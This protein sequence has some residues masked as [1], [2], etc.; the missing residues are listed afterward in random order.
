MKINKRLRKAFTLVELVVVIAIIAILSTVS[1]VTYFGITNSAK[2]SVDDTLITELNKCLQLDETINGKPNTPSEALEVV[3]EN[4]FTVEKMT[5]TQDKKEIVWH[6]TT[7]KFELV[8][9]IK[10]QNRIKNA[11]G[12]T[13]ISTWRFLSEYTAN[14]GYSVYLKDVDF[15]G[16]ALALNI[17]TGLDVGKNTEDFKISY[18]NSNVVDDLIVKTNSGE[19]SI[20]SEVKNFNHYGSADNVTIESTVSNINYQENGNVSTIVAYAGNLVVAD[21]A[22]VT[23]V[24]VDKNASAG[25]V[26]VKLPENSNAKVYAPSGIDIGIAKNHGTV[27]N[28]ENLKLGTKYYAGGQGTEV[29]PYLLETGEQAYNMKYGKGYF[30]LNADIVV[31]NEIYLSSKTVVLDLN[32]HSLRLEYGE[33][34]KPNNGGVL[35]IAGKKS[36]LTINDSSTNKTGQVIGD[37]RTYSNKVTSAIRVGNFGKLTINGGNFIGTSEGTSCIFVMTSTASSSKATVVINGGT[38]KTEIADGPKGIHYVL[39]HQDSATTG[40]TITVNGGNFY[41]YNPGVTEVDPVNAK[42]GTIK[43]ADGCKTTSK[44]VGKDTIY[45][46]SKN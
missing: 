33:G 14:G 25:S 15:S 40:C 8:D 3:E 28:I 31:K 16:K 38:F 21:N 6:Q 5:P 39:N 36:S 18:E 10:V 26:T 9:E 11:E 19:L 45:T 24:V 27:D 17:T 29:D 44:T 32:G 12:T 1:V 23:N 2:K 30:K 20:K 37:S 41:N 42:T 46:V 35:N 13:N 43:L 7:N 34:I 22:E 4:G